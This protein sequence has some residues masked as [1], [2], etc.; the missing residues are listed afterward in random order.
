M[1]ESLEKL[2]YTEVSVDD[3]CR[4]RENLNGTFREML[5]RGV[6]NKHN[7]TPREEEGNE[8][9]C[10]FVVEIPF[11]EYPEGTNLEKTYVCSNYLD[12]QYHLQQ[13]ES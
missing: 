7:F 11:T 8:K 10:A 4:R 6:I 2:D 3:Y 9:Y 1:S 12:N 13:V 5:F